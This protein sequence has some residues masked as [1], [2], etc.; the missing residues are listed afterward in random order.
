M[1]HFD[2]QNRIRQRENWKE[3]INHIYGQVKSRS[4]ELISIG[5]DNNNRYEPDIYLDHKI[6]RRRVPCALQ[7]VLVSAQHK[8]ACTI[9]PLQGQ[10]HKNQ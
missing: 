7:Q 1:Q 8:E 9:Q 6:R 3:R 2:K 5:K 4:F 10:E